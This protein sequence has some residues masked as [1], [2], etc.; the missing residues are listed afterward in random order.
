MKEYW[1]RV[2]ERVVHIIVYLIL[3]NQ[4]NWND[5]DDDDN[6]NADADNKK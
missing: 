3:I 6:N 4:M 5:D 2:L 1:T